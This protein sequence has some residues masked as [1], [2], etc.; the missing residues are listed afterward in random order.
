LKL[1]LDLVPI[2]RV[3]RL[4]LH[5]RFYIGGRD[6]PNF[7]AKLAELAGAVMGPPHASATVQLG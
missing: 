4:S 1:C 3:V 7:M 6:Q 5:E 2:D